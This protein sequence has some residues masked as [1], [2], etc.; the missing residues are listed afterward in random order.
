ML[1]FTIILVWC[2]LVAWAC[3]LGANRELAEWQ[4][5]AKRVAKTAK[6]S[7]AASQLAH[8]KA[9]MLLHYVETDREYRTLDDILSKLPKT[10]DA[11]R[12]FVEFMQMD[13][14]HFAANVAITDAVSDR[15]T[16]TKIAF[17]PIRFFTRNGQE[18]VGWCRNGW[19]ILPE[20]ALS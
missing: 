1:A 4:D 10:N 14:L 19:T 13:S 5:K 3:A 9:E 6:D 7:Q 15:I 16:C 11:G 2:F 20:R 8:D 18:Y 12:S 17:K